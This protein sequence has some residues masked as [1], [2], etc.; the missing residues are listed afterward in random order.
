MSA[1]TSDV[2]LG[3]PSPQPGQPRPRAE[4]DAVVANWFTQPPAA[5]GASKR[6]RLLAVAATA[7]V[8]VLLLYAMTLVQSQD[9][10]PATGPLQVVTVVTDKQE[11]AL[12]P[13]PEPRVRFAEPVI[14][15][16]EFQVAQP[17]NAVTAPVAVVASVQPTQTDGAVATPQMISIEDYIRAPAPRYPPGARAL[18]QKGTVVVRVFIDTTGHATEALVQRSSGFRLL[19]QAACDAV[20]AALFKP[21]SRNGVALARY[22]LIPIEFSHS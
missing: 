18:R 1:V 5:V 16:P 15:V 10:A 8:H 22:A 12:P 17:D 2:L 13:P 4:R 20:L 19:D 11:L 7:V 3:F 9:S 21:Y 14:E 6:Q